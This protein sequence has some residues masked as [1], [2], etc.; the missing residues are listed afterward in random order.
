MSSKTDFLKK[1]IKY[2]PSYLLPQ[3]EQSFPYFLKED[4]Q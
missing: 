2:I 1:V 3:G 4:V